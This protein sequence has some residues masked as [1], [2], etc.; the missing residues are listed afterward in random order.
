MGDMVDVY[1]ETRSSIRDLLEKRPAEDLDRDV[2]ATPG[3]RV[4]D[5]VAH[6]IGDV[7]CISRGDFPREFFESFGDATAIVSLNTWTAGHVSARA[8]RP[9]DELLK[10]WDEVTATIVPMMRGHNLWPEGV[11]PFA[12]RV[13]ITDLGVHQQD[14]YGTFEITRDRESPPVKI[15]VSG[16]NAT[17]DL[18]LRSDGVGA[19][20]FEAPDKRWIA[21]GDDPVATVRATRFEFFRAMSGRRSPEQL[22]SFDWSGDPEPFLPYFYPYGIRKDALDE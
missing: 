18:R 1:E 8:G 16:Y 21:G 9:L 7:D 10:E 19:L 4:R 2:P 3:W 17:M 12:D 14:I 20:S 11:P 6:L 15:G 5:V 22:L 13:L